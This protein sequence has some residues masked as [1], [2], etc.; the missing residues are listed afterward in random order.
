MLFCLYVLLLV[1]IYKTYQKNKITSI[2]LFWLIYLVVESL[3]S[4]LGFTFFKKFTSQDLKFDTE[5]Y[6]IF[7]VFVFTTIITYNFFKTKSKLLSLKGIKYKYLFKFKLSNYK[8]T[9]SI[10][11]LIFILISVKMFSENMNILN[12]LS[13]NNSRAL[14]GSNTS[15]VEFLLYKMGLILIG[16]F[17]VKGRIMKISLIEKV[18]FGIILFY[19]FLYGGRF[20]VFASLLIFSLL[21]YGEKIKNITKT[22]F[23][24]AIITYYLISVSYANVRYYSIS[25]RDIVKTFTYKNM[26][27]TTLMQLGGNLV[28]FSLVSENILK[29]DLLKEK[30]FPT[31]L[32][33]FLPS[34]VRESFFD[35][36]FQKRV[37]YGKIFAEST[38]QN[39]NSLRLNFT[40]EVFFSFGYI[41]VVFYGFIVGLSFS[42]F[43][44]SSTIQTMAIGVF[45]FVQLLSLHILGSN[46]FS[47]TVILTILFILIINKIFHK[48]NGV[49]YYT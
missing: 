31:I 36:Y 47:N 28:D 7:F 2:F 16:L 9:I 10:L 13:S 20:L 30:F 12:F 38:G 27:S 22:K 4:F 5:F 8:N 6:Y 21:Y 49:I 15:G 3:V 26:A 19:Y 14:V 23:I 43:D 41:G 1:Y 25:E 48:Q 46:T 33:G 42:F 45:F 37:N 40:N 32:E 11:F 34:F 44:K 18:L 39:D 17:A 24:L 35:S 29:R